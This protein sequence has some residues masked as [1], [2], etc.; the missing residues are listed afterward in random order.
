MGKQARHDQTDHG[1][2]AGLIN[3]PHQI[4]ETQ[5]NLTIVVASDKACHERV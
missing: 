3:R 1:L 2:R 4:I 5:P